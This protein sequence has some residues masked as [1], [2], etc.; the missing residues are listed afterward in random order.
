[1][2]VIAVK[3]IMGMDRYLEHASCFQ[4]AFTMRKPRV[5]VASS[6]EAELVAGAIADNLEGSAEVTTWWQAFNLGGYFVDELVRNLAESD[7]GVFV[8]HPDDKLQIREIETATTRDN[9]IFELGMFVGKL[10][11]ERSFIVTPSGIALRL[12]T[13]L[14]GITV[15]NYDI[16]RV[17]KNEARP[18]LLSASNRIAEA[19]RR[20]AEASKVQVARATGRLN[21]LMK[22]SL[23]TVCRAMSI[24]VTPGDVSLRA[25][26][27]RKESEE[28]VCRHYWDP[29]PSDEE[30]GVTRFKIDSAVAKEVVVVRC[31]L[32]KQLRSSLP[33]EDIAASGVVR[34]LPADFE[35]VS[36]NVKPDL[37]FVLAA[38]IRDDN[39]DIWGVVDFDTSN[40]DG[41]QLLKG[42]WAKSTIV[43]L[44]RQL[45]NILTEP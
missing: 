23:E 11:K 32:D 2:T 35:G 8:F 4:G 40:R 44:A 27:F 31:F 10:G 21:A 29:N 45:K 6:A 24:P 18:A 37:T 30:V 12:P 28:L 25:F 43:S 34:P 5:F 19:I 16:N 38:P 20:Q 22:D 13:D 14:L 39:D 26:I 42:K 17:K 15:A 36:G 3:S 41:E 33:E 7:F 9:V 1:M